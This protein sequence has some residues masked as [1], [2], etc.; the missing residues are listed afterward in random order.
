MFAP[1]RLSLL[2]LTC[3]ASGCVY[4]PLDLGLG[5]MGESY[6]AKLSEGSDDEKVLLLRLDGEITGREDDGF[7]SSTPATTSQV[8]LALDRARQDPAVRAVLLRINSP[9]GGVTASD[10]IHHELQRFRAETQKPIVAWFGDTAASGGYYAAMAAGQ[11]VAA[12]TSITGSIGVIAVFPNVEGL[13]DKLGVKVEAITSGDFKDAGSMYRAMRADERAYLQK[14]ID[15]MYARFVDT[16][17]AGRAKAGLSR[18]DVLALA[19]GRVFTGPEALEAK[20]VDR[21]GYL[22]DALALAAEAAGLSEPQLVAY[23]RRGLSNDVSSVYSAPQ[24]Q[25]V[26]LLAPDPT[27]QALGKALPDAG[28]SLLYRWRF[29]R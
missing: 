21:V 4:A 6:E 7:L 28:P 24:A 23:E 3:A 1:L 25:A 22:E 26:R 10:V 14:L 13:G 27:L 17:A 5:K 15:S 16:V 9:G 29:G 8:R 20:L 18:D 12:P 19:D 11:I 2:A